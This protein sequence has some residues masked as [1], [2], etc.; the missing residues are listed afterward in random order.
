MTALPRRIA[1]ERKRDERWRSRAHCDFV[2]SHECCVPGCVGR[3][4]EVAHL[5]NGSDA[6]MARKPSDFYTISACRFHHDQQHNIGEKSFASMYQ[7]D[8]HALAQAFSEA[9]PKKW[10]IAQQKIDR[11]LV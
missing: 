8:L 3:P 7:I 6:G 5:R 4:I 1:K 9:S 2:R 11:G 10:E